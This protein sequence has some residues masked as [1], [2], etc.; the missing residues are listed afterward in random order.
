MG[1][2]EVCTTAGRGRADAARRSRYAPLMDDSP[3]PR[4]PAAPDLPLETAVLLA[5]GSE[6]TVGETRDTNSGDL[7]RSL[8]QEGVEVLW[9]SALPDQ[10]GTV[11]GALSFARGAPCSA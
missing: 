9:I 5:I 11:E 7:A 6:L 8:S 1:G 3:D 2:S 10:R 4:T